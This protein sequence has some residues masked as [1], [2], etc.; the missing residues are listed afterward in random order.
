ML[1]APEQL[2]H[3]RECVRQTVR[4][5]V[6]GP[7]NLQATGREVGRLLRTPTAATI[8]AAGTPRSRRAPITSRPSCPVA[9]VTASRLSPFPSV[10][11]INGSVEAPG[12]LRSEALVRVPVRLS[13]GELLRGPARIGA[14]QP[15]HHPDLVGNGQP[16]DETDDPGCQP[17]PAG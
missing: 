5:V 7:A 1:A 13:L 11:R 10:G 17:Q 15:V 6:V 9:P 8:E 16:R 3:P 2:V 4:L 12:S 14:K